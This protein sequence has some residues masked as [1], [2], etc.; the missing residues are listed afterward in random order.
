[1]L[2]CITIETP[3]RPDGQQSVFQLRTPPMSVVR[4]GI[5]G[6]G[7]RGQKAVERLRSIE[8]AEIAALCD[9][10][11]ERVKA[12][13]EKFPN[14]PTL[15]T[16]H[17]SLIT[18][19]IDLIYI[20]TDWA[21]HVPIALEAMNAGKH[22][23]IEV[24]AAMTLEDCWALV[25]T[26]ERTQRHCTMLENCCYDS[27]HLSALEAVRKG[28]FG[29][30]VHVEGAYIH[31]IGERWTPWRIAVNRQ[32]RG[33]LYPTHGMGP[34]CQLL[35]IHR[36]DRLETLVSMDTNAFQRDDFRNGDHTTTLMRTRNGKTILLQHNVVSPHEYTRRY[37]VVGTR[38]SIESS[39]STPH[40]L[41]SQRMDSRLIEC[42]HRGIPLDIDVYDLAEWCAVSELSRISIE[43]GSQ[44]VA[45]PDFLRLESPKN[46]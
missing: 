36:S 13:A 42:L 44:P 19:N 8:H 37:H 43:N 35:D 4:I 20:C 1:M 41:M 15:I 21:S 34:A 10:S 3:K 18:Q 30:V 24:P 5:V 32:L 9:V 27:R 40:D 17:S 25:D 6:L 39:D 7:E 16:H 22:V 12:V 38:Q 11:E 26:A 14:K 2:H 45:F 33:D 31:P 28:D 46:P 29:T 23:A